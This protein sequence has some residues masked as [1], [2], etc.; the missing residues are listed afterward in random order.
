M[1]FPPA[2]F[3]HLYRSFLVNLNPRSSFLLLLPRSFPTAIEFEALEIHPN[4]IVYAFKQPQFILLRFRREHFFSAPKWMSRIHHQAIT[5]ASSR[6]LFYSAPSSTRGSA[7]EETPC[8]NLSQSSGLSFYL[9][10]K[11]GTRSPGTS[12]RRSSKK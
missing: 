3:I 5:Q 9:R 2:R 1:S 10:A 8:R 7:P 6:S 11:S 4:T 12:R